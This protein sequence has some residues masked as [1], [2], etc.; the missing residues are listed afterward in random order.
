ML[1][2]I[3]RSGLV[4]TMLLGLAGQ[5]VAVAPRAASHGGAECLDV[6]VSSALVHPTSCRVT[7]PTSLVVA[8][9]DPGNARDTKVVL[10]AEQTRRIVTLS[11]T[12]SAR[13]TDVRNGHAC[14][15]TDGGQF[16]VETGTG[17]VAG[18]CSSTSQP[19][20]TL[21]SAITAASSPQASFK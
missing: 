10:V 15:S 17:R 4:A 2:G 3:V 1:G 21:T 16:D 20:M 13:I 14:I 9:T 5:G 6:P 11:G 19:S 12:G 7:G 18:S 8:G